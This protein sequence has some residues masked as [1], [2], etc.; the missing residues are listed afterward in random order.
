MNANEPQSTAESR[1]RQIL[2]V[3]LTPAMVRE[4]KQEAAR[5]GMTVRKLFEEMWSIYREA[6]TRG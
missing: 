1:S 2:G 3:S 4:V 5:R 6:R